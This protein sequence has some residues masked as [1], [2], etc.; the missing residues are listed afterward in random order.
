MARSVSGPSLARP[1]VALVAV[2]ALVALAVPTGATSGAASAAADTPGLG[3]ADLRGP[4]VAPPAQRL[5]RVA[6]LGA[7]ATWNR[8][9]TP[10]TLTKHGGWLATGLAGSPATAARAWIRA[11]RTLFGLSDGAVT[12]LTLVNH[13][14]LRDSTAHVVSFRQRFGSLA[15]TEDGLITVGIRGGRVGFVSSSIAPAQGTPASATVPA[16]AAWVTAASHVG[17]SITQGQLTG[18]GTE[19]GWTTFLAPGLSEVQRVRLVAVP[20]PAGVRPAFEA[21]VVDADGGE[22]LAYTVFVDAITNQVLVR[23]DQV[24]HLALQAPQTSTFTGTYTATSCGPFHGPYTAPAGTVS[25]DVSAVGAVVNDIILELHHPQGTVVA[26]SDIPLGPNPETIH[27][28]PPVVPP[29]DYFVRVCPF[30]ENQNPPMT[31]VGS[32]TI[33]DT[34]SPNVAYPPKWRVF[35]ANPPLDL[36]NADVRELWCWVSEVDGSPIP[37]CD[38]ELANLAAR[39]PWDHDVRTGAPTF[40]TKG[41]AA[42]AGEAWGS[43]LTP[44]EQ[45][46]PVAPDREYDFPWTDQWQ[47]AD[48][49]QT[50]FASPQRNDIDAAITNLFAMHNRMHDWSYFLGFTE[51]AYNLQDSNF[52]LTQPGPFPTGR[53]ND[54]EVGNAQ[55]GAVTGG[56]PSYLGRDNA[57]QITL[58][59]GVPGITNMYLW[60]PIAAAFYPP[61]VDGDYDMSVIGHEYTHAISNRMIGGPDAGIT[62]SQGRAMGESWS[63]LAAV[64]Y[65][66]EFGFVPTAGENPF[67]V[68]PYVTGDHQSGIRNYGMNDSPLNFSDMTYDFVCDA[69][70][71][72]PPIEPPCDG[73]IQP[74][75]DGEIWSAI[76]YDIRQALIQKYDGA[77]PASDAALQRACADGQRAADQCPGNRRWIQIMFD[78]FLLMP[79]DV[80]FLGARDAYLGADMLRFG[81]ANQAELWREFAR[82]GIGEAASAAD[83]EDPQPVPS[84]E[85]PAESNEGTITFDVRAVEDGAAVPAEIYVGRYEARVTPIAD[86]DVATALGATAAFVPGT[87]ELIARADG[88]GAFRFSLDIAANETRTVQVNLPRNHASTSNGASA[89]GDGVGHD[90]LID[91]TE[92]TNWSVRAR[93]PNVAGAAVTI[94]LAGSAPIDVKRVQVSAMLRPPDPDDPDDPGSQNRFTALRRF[95]VL[96]CTAAVANAGCTLPTGFTQIYTSP[97]DAFPAVAPRPRAPDLILREFDVPDTMATHLRLVVVTNQCTGGPAY[98]GDQ[99]ADPTNDSDCQSGSARDQDVRA[100]EFQAFAAAGSLGGGGG[101]GTVTGHA[102]TDYSGNGQAGQGDVHVSV[103]TAA[104][105]ATPTQVAYLDLRKNPPGTPSSSFRCIGTPEATESVSPNTVQLDG[106]V[107]CDGFSRART[108]TLVITDNG[109]NPPNRDGYD[110]TLYNRSGGVVYGWTDLTTA[111]LGDLI[112]S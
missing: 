85:S 83:G 66:N 74:H 67:A 89:G 68:G 99:D 42:I 27:Y 103:G 9:G 32:I 64:E 36:S 1:V 98:Q 45:Y 80:D 16:L 65:L 59:D 58:Q 62:S 81:G 51:S 100:A 69:S 104:H 20:T 15:P 33:N 4:R 26:A 23:R 34:V 2:L 38:R 19:N 109:T 11:N 90:N 24:D 7:S 84:F 78:A 61:C 12:G 43:P 28:A 5:D 47:E 87:Y 93:T 44:A 53:E 71:V 92:A 110:M 50:V 60:Q 72:G 102:H 82:G 55:A 18:V 22:A 91:D 63:D 56:A 111:G 76:N 41:N 54:P 39:A 94:N 96:A 10:S 21:N 49:S 6:A 77:F 70:L 13:A 73:P 52:G 3:D 57:N 86:T 79:S 88:Y 46:R 101:G 30:D 108:F 8:F 31:Y 112:V 105:G 40:T 95:E 106:T 48:C 75:A 25:I 107:A 29:G 17:L 14:R 97:A 35:P 37:G